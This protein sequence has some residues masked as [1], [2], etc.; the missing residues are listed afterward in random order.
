MVSFSVYLCP[1]NILFIT[2]SLSYRYVSMFSCHWALQ[3]TFLPVRFVPNYFSLF[4]LL[5]FTYFPTKPPLPSPFLLQMETLVQDS[6]AFGVPE[7]RKW[8]TE[9]FWR[10]RSKFILYVHSKMAIADDSHIILGSTNLHQRSLDGAR[11]TELSVS[12]NQVCVCVTED[13]AYNS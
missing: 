8:S 12:A 7:P 10:R 6:R 11:D 4:F 1:F 9:W 13:D 2:V 3:L 5:P